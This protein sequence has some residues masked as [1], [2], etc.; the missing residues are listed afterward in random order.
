MDDKAPVR[1][2]NRWHFSDGT[3]LPVISGGDGPDD[4]GNDD[5]N[6]PAGGDPAGGDPAAGGDPKFSQAE[7]DAIA[8][9]A[10]GEG[11][12]AAE[13]ELLKALGV[14]DVETAKAT[15]Q[16]ARELEDA[17]KSEL[18]RAQTAAQELTKRAEEAE[19]S[20]RETL[21]NSSVESA[22]REAGINPARVKTAMKLIDRSAIEV[23][24][25]EVKGVTEAV[26]ALKTETAE[27]FGATAGAPDMTRTT[28]DGRRNF[29]ELSR[30]ERQEEYRRRGINL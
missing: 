10:R 4:D 23:D 9:K 27:W 29:T 14:T 3:T 2:G 30:E 25:S 28:G 7:L 8:G 13:K 21:V 6:D 15:L 17:Q 18:E 16:R 26:A 5:G 1:F 24:G 11:R 12:T 22:L 19:G 20:L